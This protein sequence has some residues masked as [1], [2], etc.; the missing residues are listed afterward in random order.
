LG[1]V[2]LVTGIVESLTKLYPQ[3]EID[4]LTSSQYAPLFERDI[5]FAS[6]LGIE[7]LGDQ[8]D[9]RERLKAR[10][11][12]F[13]ADL[14]GNARSRLISRRVGGRYAAYSS[15]AL[16]R[17]ALVRLK[18]LRLSPARHAIERYVTAFTRLGIVVEPGIPAIKLT[19]DEVD[20]FR[21]ELGIAESKPVGLVP[22]AKWPAK[23]WPLSHFAELAR[24]IDFAPVIA[25]GDSTERD[26][27]VGLQLETSGKVM[28]CETGDVRRL[29]RALASCR[30]VVT[31]DSGPMHLAAA[32]GIPV[33]SMF[34]P[35]TRA[36]GF[37][38]V[39]PRVAV[40]ERELACRPCHVHGGES[41]KL[42]QRICLESIQ[43]EEV[44][45][46]IECL[47]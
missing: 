3:W 46:M 15:Q 18:F 39:G 20:T 21:A 33:V 38:P 22:G 8:S 35:T 41:C 45:G 12:D 2:V 42:G 30:V 10:R 7:R 43:P 29:A 23:M 5:R 25:L 36:L 31:N 6:V 40:M 47:A 34:G 4:F 19:E 14:Q 26:I 17:R 1:D 16:R 9:I 32:L 44:L 24:L 27:L 37:A 28:T 11:Y 13:V